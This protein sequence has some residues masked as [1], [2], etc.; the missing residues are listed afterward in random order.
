MSLGTA[1]KTSHFSTKNSYITGD[2]FEQWLKGVFIPHVEATRES[3]RRRLGTFDERAVLIL[4][5]C[6]SHTNKQYRTLL[7]S[8]NI[9]M[10]FLVP[11][12]SHLAQ[13]LD[14]NIFGRVKNLIR[15]EATYGVSVEEANEALDDIIGDIVPDDAPPRPRPPCAELGK[16]LAKY[17]TAIIDAYE[18]ATTRGLVVSAFRQAG[19]RYMIPDTQSPARR[20]S[21]VDRSEARAVKADKGLFLDLR[22]VDRPAPG[23]VPI[24]DLI[25]NPQTREGW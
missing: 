5:G 12:T 15:D 19:I 13:P 23:P 1:R 22:P 18:R 7:E 4:D 17:L 14:L 16:A 21:S 24:A 20:V 9:T 11:H 10:L 2:V 6:S 3:L 8:K 25:S